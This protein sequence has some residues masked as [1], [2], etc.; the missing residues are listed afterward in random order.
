MERGLDMIVSAVYFT[1]ENTSSESSRGAGRR[2]TK[3]T[4]N[5]NGHDV[6]YFVYSKIKIQ[7]NIF[8]LVF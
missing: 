3:R 1:A 8:F 7:P 6:V 4:K 2:Y 5:R